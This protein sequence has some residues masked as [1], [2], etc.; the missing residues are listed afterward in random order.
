MSNHW[1]DQ[2]R[3]PKGSEEGGQWTDE[4]ISKATNAAREGANLPKKIPAK[5]TDKTAREFIKE[6]ANQM[7]KGN[8]YPYVSDFYSDSKLGGLSKGG[9]NVTNW[10]IKTSDDPG[11]Y[12]LDKDE[13]VVG[14]S[15]WGKKF[16]INFV[17]DQDGWYIP[18]GNKVSYETRIQQFLAGL[19]YSIKKVYLESYD[20]GYGT[21]NV[22]FSVTF[23]KKND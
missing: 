16:G 13:F 1:K 22:N 20:A 14:L 6:I 19:G 23:K 8:M 21:K 11:W 4:N 3:I 18:E 9:V 17:N 5:F 12:D 7:E 2:P 10:T 15:V